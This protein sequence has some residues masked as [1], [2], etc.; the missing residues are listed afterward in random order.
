MH[1]GPGWGPTCWEKE[2]VT[3]LP[4]GETFKTVAGERCKKT[5]SDRKRKTT[6]NKNNK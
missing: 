4:A 3:G 2:K 6:E 5:T 1:D